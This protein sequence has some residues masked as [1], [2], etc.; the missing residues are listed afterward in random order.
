M[1]PR[2]AEQKTAE[3][4]ASRIESLGIANQCHENLL[5]HVF[6]YRRAPAH[7]QREPVYRRLLPPV[8][9]RKRALVAGHHPPQQ[10][11]VIYGFNAPVHLTRLDGPPQ[12]S[13]HIPP[14]VRKSSNKIQLLTL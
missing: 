10:Q 2:D 4:P 14:P 6:R 11:P 12:L 7:V 3:R 13:L 1:I 8:Q 9:K 5:R